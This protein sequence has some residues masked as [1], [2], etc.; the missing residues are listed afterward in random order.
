MGLTNHGNQ[1]ITYQYYIEATGANFGKRILDIVPPGIYSGG[2]L[3]R[4]SDS[5]ITLSTL[6]AEIRDATNQIN[7]RTV[8]SDTLN[9]TTLDSGAISSATPYIVL[10]WAYAAS[11]INYVEIHA[12][13]NVASALTNDIIIGK[14]LF[15]GSVLTGFSYTER[16]FLNVQNLFLK[17]EESS[18]LYIQLRA[19]RIHTSTGFVLVPEQQVGPFTVPSSPNSRID[20]VYISSTGTAA[21]LQGTQGVSPVA[22]SYSGKLAL[23]Q[24]TIVNG[25]TSIPADR[26]VDVRAFIS[27]GSGG[28]PDDSTL[29]KSGDTW[30]VKDTGITGA[31]LNTNVADGS[32]LEKSGT[33]LRVKALGINYLKINSNVA[34]GVTIEKSGTTGKLQVKALGITNDKINSNVVDGVTLEK[35]GTTGKLKVVTVA[36][37]PSFGAWSTK[38]NNTVYTAAT[39]GF[40]CAIPSISSESDAYGYTDSANPPVTVRARGAHNETWINSSIIMPV[41]K[42]D[43]WKVINCVSIYW[44]PL[45]S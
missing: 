25:D 24:V 37:A 20:V 17:V 13:A 1:T 29:E 40:V 38:A 6:I 19:G 12:I 45:G 2:Y 31:K 23:A 14:C 11:S 35:D 34:D 27:A 4:V 9:S 32:T 22:P 28:V 3:T 8:A 33:S 18:G 39:D 42:G 44:L 36:A 30:R 5:I 10:R 16:T 26:I 43:Y 7:V 21:I 15:S 41:R